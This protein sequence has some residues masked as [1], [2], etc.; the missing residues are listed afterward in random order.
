MS[1]WIS[2]KDLDDEQ[3]QAVE[4]ISEN[5]S[6]LISGPA[7]SGKTNILLLRA[8][9]LSYKGLPDYKIIAFTSSLCEFMRHGCNQ[10][11]LNPDVVTTQ[12]SFF[13][14]ILEEYGVEHTAQDDFE[15]E[16]QIISGKV[17]SLV[18]SKKISQEYCQRILVDECQD[19]S[20]TE[21]LIFTR[22]CRS[23]VFA[24]DTRQS[25]YSGTHSIGYPESLV[26]G[27]VVDLKYHYRSGLHL[28]SV[29]DEVLADR[30]RYAPVKDRCR[31][32]EEDMPS[33][34]SSVSLA[35]IDEQYEAILSNVQN[36]LEL[37]PK[38][39]IGVLFPKREM[40]EQ[41]RKHPSLLALGSAAQRIQ[42]LTFHSAKGW[43]FRAVHVAGC[44]SASRMGATQKRLVYTAILRGQTSAHF[45][46]TG[47]I[48]PYLE[49]ALE[50]QLPPKQNPNFE[51]LF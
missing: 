16:R 42:V 34:V 35:S 22:L 10:Y 18:E 43:E 40:V 41:F 12:I 17:L 5:T 48:P 39:R 31:Y 47:H 37:Y 7:G 38:E 27:K 21:L 33:S 50:S 32:P 6:F 28:C 29:A 14:R 25:I 46:Y 36:Q 45:Y 2:A 24:S 26:N 20:D 9:W 30:A 19:Y 4:G 11:G 8:K 49:K 3:R 15:T 23:V 13:R 51:S 44:E 1:F